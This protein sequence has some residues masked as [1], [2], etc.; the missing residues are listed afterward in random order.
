M[1]ELDDEDAFDDMDMAASEDGNES[2]HMG[3]DDDDNPEIR[4]APYVITMDDI[5]ESTL[6]G[7]PA[8]LFSR[9]K[10]TF[11]MPVAASLFDDG[12]QV[13]TETHLD[14]L[15]ALSNPLYFA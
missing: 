12:I 4:D 10:S 2:S 8:T 14:Y 5:Q 15:L 13:A 3:D 6:A 7:D 9:K 1:V 11:P